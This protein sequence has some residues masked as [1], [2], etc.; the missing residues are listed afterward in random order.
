MG[1]HDADRL[2]GL[3]QQRLVA[4]QVLE[5]SDDRVEGRPAPGRSAAA[6]V[7]H[8]LVGVLRHLG[9]E[10]VHEHAEGALL[11]PAPA[12]EVEP[13]GRPYG[14]C[15]GKSRHGATLPPVEAGA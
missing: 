11:L 8:E 13:A 2:A 10:V 12:G 4:P 14:P 15:A 1:G 5:G 9:I 7:D 3:D 6:A